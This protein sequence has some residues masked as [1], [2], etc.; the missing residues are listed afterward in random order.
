MH[1]AILIKQVHNA[2][3]TRLQPN[4]EESPTDFHINRLDEHAL[5][6]ALRIK[7][8]LQGTTLTLVSVGPH[9]VTEALKRG[10]GMGADEAVH[11]KTDTEPLSATETAAALFPLLS[12]LAPD[13]ILCGAM[14]EDLM[15]GMTGP[16]LAAMLGIPYTSQ[17]IKELHVIRECRSL[18]V[19][20][21]AGGGSRQVLS[22]D[23][24]C[25]VTIQQGFNTPRYP[26][27]THMIKARTRPIQCREAPAAPDTATAHVTGTSPP[28]QRGRGIRIKGSPEAQAAQFVAYL[29]ERQVLQG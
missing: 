9:R 20:R 28:T 12:E 15:Q 17:A 4:R 2:G 11:V 18:E 25:L 16:A 19:T 3:L 1:I 26:N 10:L 21:D 5:E 29:K 14:S 23:F 13:L 6:E 7:E 24:P 27:I 8:S 22:L